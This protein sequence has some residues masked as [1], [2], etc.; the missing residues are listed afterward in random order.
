MKSHGFFSRRRTL[1]L[2]LSVLFGVILFAM[3]F[4]LD[5]DS[6]YLDVAN[7]PFITF[8][9]VAFLFAFC[10][11]M[12]LGKMLIWGVLSGFFAV[13]NLV[14]RYLGFSDV[15][16]FFVLLLLFLLTGAFLQEYLGRKRKNHMELER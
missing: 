2:F 7:L 8:L 15:I 10:I 3:F 5:P 4:F 6:I 13:T 14:L 16:Y 1:F 12:F 11:G 9:V